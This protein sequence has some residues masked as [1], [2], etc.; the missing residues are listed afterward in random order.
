MRDNVD[1]YA[2]DLGRRADR[3][4][5]KQ[6]DLSVSV[7]DL[8]DELKAQRDAV[9]RLACAQESQAAKVL[10]T[11]ARLRQ[12]ATRLSKLTSVVADADADAEDA[13]ARLA[14]ESKAD[15]AKL[16]TEMGD[17]IARQNDLSRAEIV[18][19]VAST[20]G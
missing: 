7:T 18:P 14:D 17:L 6:E 2:A 15:R 19:A 5:G 9:S 11:L 4:L 1:D 13:A 10:T 8:I 20:K 12:C 16:E 3:L